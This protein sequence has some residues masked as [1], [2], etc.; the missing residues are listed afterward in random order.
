MMM[1]HIL[2]WFLSGAGQDIP[3]DGKTNC[4]RRRTSAV[5]SKWATCACF[6]QWSLICLNNAWGCNSNWWMLF[7]VASRD[8]AW[9][10]SDMYLARPKDTN[11]SLTEHVFPMPGFHVT[12]P[13]VNSQLCILDAFYATSTSF[14]LVCWLLKLILRYEACRCNHHTHHQPGSLR[15]LC[16]FSEWSQMH[17]TC[18]GAASCIF[19]TDE[20]EWQTQPSL[21]V[22]LLS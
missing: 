12:L 8:P 3:R 1:F 13:F 10:E 20:V 17:T 15:M 18:V 19:D 2:I 11:V 7:L 16:E 6:T 14:F 21:G 9:F 5:S 22:S 4:T